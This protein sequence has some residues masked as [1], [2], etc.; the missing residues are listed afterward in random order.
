MRCTKLFLSAFVLFMG[1]AQRPDAPEGYDPELY[2]K[3]VEIAQSTIILDGHVDVPYRLVGQQPK[4]DISGATANG[5]FD[6]PRAKKGGLNAPFMSIYIPAEYQ[7]EPGASKKHAESLIALMDSIIAANPDQFAAAITPQDVR[8]NFEDG[9]ISF[10]YGMENGSAIE[11][12]LANVAHFYNEGVRYITLTH[13][14]KNLICDSSFDDDKG[15]NGLSPFGRQV[16]AEMNRLGMM[17]DISHVSDS[18]FYQVLRLAKVAPI[19]SHSSCR[20]FTPGLER[21]VNDDMLKALGEKGGVI[22]INF[23][24]FFLTKEANEKGWAQWQHQTR[25]MNDNGITNQ[26]DPRVKAEM[27]QYEKEN[28]F[29]YATVEDVVDHIDHVV[30]IA[31]IDHVGLGSD[32]DGVGPTLPIGLKSVADYPNLI[33]HLLKRGYSQ[34]DIEKILSGNVLRVWQEAVDYAVRQTEVSLNR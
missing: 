34:E 18:T 8:N 17:V 24:S 15:W 11:D 3:A 6:Y 14:K 16:V 32:F 29:P 2:Q 9:L 7:Q 4:E 23:G 13:S 21:N 19:C 27:E 22:Q 1:C 25:F 26:N 10:P 5:N 31:G 33:C 28:P 12:D 30:E 20:H